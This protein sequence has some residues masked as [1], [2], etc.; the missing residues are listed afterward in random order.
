[1]TLLNTLK[2]TISTF[3]VVTGIT[4]SMSFF[5]VQAQTS[6]VH[7]HNLQTA[8][9]SYSSGDEVG[10]KFKITN[11]SG[12]A[13]SDVFYVF[14]TGFYGDEGFLNVS[15]ETERVG[16]LFLDS[17][18]VL[19][20][21]YAQV[22]KGVLGKQVFLEVEV[23]KR[24]GSEISSDVVPVNLSD[25]EVLQNE[26]SSIDS[27]DVSIA[28]SDLQLI[29]GQRYDLG[30]VN[31]KDTIKLLVDYISPD[32]MVSQYKEVIGGELVFEEKM[33]VED[34]TLEVPLGT[35]AG[36]YITRLTFME[37]EYFYDITHRVE[38]V[39]AS[40]TAINISKKGVQK[41]D[42]FSV[43]IIYTGGDYRVFSEI[44]AVE[45]SEPFL[46]SELQRGLQEGEGGVVRVN[47]SS[48]FSEENQEKR[49]EIKS[50]EG[51]MRVTVYDK[52][53]NIVA[54]GV[55][56]I[57]L[58]D[59]EER[60][61]FPLVAKVS[62]NDLTVVVEIIDAAGKRLVL[63][64]LIVESDDEAAFLSKNLTYLLG[65]VILFILG[66]VILIIRKKR[67][68]QIVPLALLI[69]L[70]GAFGLNDVNAAP[71][72]DVECTVDDLGRRGCQEVYELTGSELPQQ[73]EGVTSERMDEIASQACI[74]NGYQQVA[75]G[76]PSRWYRD[77]IWTGPEKVVCFKPIECANNI[78]QY[79]PGDDAPVTKKISS[80]VG[81]LKSKNSALFTRSGQC[82]SGG[83]GCIF[84]DSY[85]EIFNTDTNR[86]NICHLAGYKNYESYTDKKQTSQKSSSLLQADFTWR[87]ENKG[88]DYVPRFQEIREVNPGSGEMLSCNPHLP[89]SC[90]TLNVGSSCYLR[91]DD[92]LK[93]ANIPNCSLNQASYQAGDAVKVTCTEMVSGTTLSITDMT[94][95]DT[96]QGVI[97]CAGTYGSGSGL[98][99]DNELDRIG[100]NYSATYASIFTCEEIKNDG[101]VIDTLVCKN[102]I[103]D[104]C[105][106]IDGYQPVPPDG[107]T[108]NTAGVC[109]QFDACPN[110][111]SIETI[112]PEGF[113]L[114]DAG[115]C[116][117]PLLD[118]CPDIDGTQSSIPKGYFQGT[119]GIC[120]ENSGGGGPTDLCPDIDGTQSS[121]PK[122]YFQGTDGICVENSGGGGPTDLCLNIDDLQTSVPDGLVRNTA[123]DCLNE[124]DGLDPCP[125]GFLKG[126]NGVCVELEKSSGKVCLLNDGA[127]PQLL[128]TD[129]QH[130][131]LKSEDLFQ[132]GLSVYKMGPI[133]VPGQPRICNLAE[134]TPGMTLTTT[135]G[136][137]EPGGVCTI[138]LV[139]GG[140]ALCELE[141]VTGILDNLSVCNNGTGD[142][143]TKPCILM[144]D[145]SLSLTLE[146]KVT[147]NKDTG[148]VLVNAVCGLNKNG[149]GTIDEVLFEREGE[150]RLTPNIG[151]F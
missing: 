105:T 120:V 8:Q 103:V 143:E 55:S 23:Q 134:N 50:V 6:N 150:C 102:P 78:C 109:T 66:I 47:G 79:D 108:Q 25:T 82:A 139:A 93:L 61:T 88:P 12:E 14:R 21:P 53:Q 68:N 7:V 80:V 115:D 113:V 27:P 56:G 5:Q 136:F 58:G 147:L 146:G 16:P 133:S 137:I 111:E 116:V 22:I 125:K 30:L 99:N 70:G 95:S 20:I 39:S 148:S 132:V 110:T 63:S 140:V 96:E 75:S 10:G 77:N 101:Q 129:N 104:A 59:A 64:N 48:M 107:Y 87:D 135:P 35:E 69:F 52:K 2:Q 114:D 28:D 45:N 84:E 13:Q 83:W 76:F 128:I 100:L 51:E 67:S 72:V 40:I 34:L 74:D 9:M 89:S 44:L 97:T 37:G 26:Y 85:N 141:L 112:I 86:K 3:L 24:D 43:E 138:N 122:G 126:T 71:I 131:Y 94:C 1:M 130:A 145:Q 144:A 62:S 73:E 11:T 36:R 54:E 90:T 18:E 91:S 81:L 32:V 124:I 149:D 119:D 117:L 31:Q 123:G 60:K 57:E 65:I 19:T 98:V 41:K 92:D 142:S 17:G 29:L 49:F 121:I 118:L 46:E 4:L 33:I 127:G 106:N 42:P 151:E 38:G 15:S